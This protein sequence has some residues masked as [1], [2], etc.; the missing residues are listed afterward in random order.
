M[1]GTRRTSLALE[2]ERTMTERKLA[3]G[4]E[5][6]A[7]RRRRGWTQSELA[8]RAGVGRLVV[9]RIERGTTRLDVDALVRVALALGRRLEVGFARDRLEGPLD[10]GHLAVQELV[11]RV[12]RASGMTTAFELPDRPS[13]PIR[14]I[15]VALT[16]PKDHIVIVCECW[17]TI[18]DIGA[19]ARSTARKVAD[20]AAMAAGRWGSDASATS[21]WVVRATA[22]NR[23]LVAR[24]REVFERRFPSSSR[25]WVDALVRGSRP[26]MEPGLVWCDV[27]A[28]RLVEWRRRGT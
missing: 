7:A 27:G 13:D 23:A 22:M 4:R 12:A 10:A 20:A 11:L 21:V 16:R 1:S 2:A 15:D 5:V 17:N 24:Y 14:S 18:G 9:G 6:R 19:A 26:P 3:L 8:R 28:T 25:A